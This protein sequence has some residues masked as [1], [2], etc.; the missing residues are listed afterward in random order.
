M[1]VRKKGQYCILCEAECALGRHHSVRHKGVRLGMEEL[2]LSISLVCFM[3]S[4][5]PQFHRFVSCCVVSFPFRKLLVGLV[6]LCDAHIC[7][8]P[9]SG[10]SQRAA[11]KDNSNFWI[12]TLRF[13]LLAEAI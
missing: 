9:E 7:S 3:S 2:L 12:P 5:C 8:R 10:L 1:Q 13:S 4:C 11:C 6:R